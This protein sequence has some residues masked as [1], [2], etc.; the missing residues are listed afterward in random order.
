MCSWVDKAFPM[1]LMILGWVLPIPPL[2][3]AMAG[4]ETGKGGGARRV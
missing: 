3:G 4:L 1:S 2:F